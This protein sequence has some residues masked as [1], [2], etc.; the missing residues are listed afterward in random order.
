MARTIGTVTITEQITRRRTYET[1][2][3]YMDFEVEPQTVELTGPDTRSHGISGFTHYGAAAEGV[4][5][6]S[7][8][9]SS[10]A[11]NVHSSK[12]DE[13]VGERDRIVVFSSNYLHALVKAA[14]A[15]ERDGVRVELDEEAIGADVI[16]AARAFN[17]RVEESLARSKAARENGSGIF[18]GP[19]TRYEG[20]P[21]I[22]RKDSIGGTVCR[23]VDAEGVERVGVVESVEYKIDDGLSYEVVMESGEVVRVV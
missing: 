10:F 14:D 5:T 20:Q 6:G 16:E 4:C 13:H 2:S 9:A 3:W 23:V 18:Y 8:F 22:T 11:G 19:G 21:V 7:Y 1:A 17:R 12:V 15:G